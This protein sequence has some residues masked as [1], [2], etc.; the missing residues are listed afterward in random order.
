MKKE[1]IYDYSFIDVNGEEHSLS[2]FR[3]K[4]ILIVNTAIH[5]SFTSTY[6]DLQRT[7]LKY[8]QEGLEIIDFPCNQFHGQAS[9]SIEE[10]DKFCRE[11]YQ[12]TFL[13]SQKVDVV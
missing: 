4:I 1:N 9:E 3:G 8:H 5:C 10:I 7:Y 12:T 6:K 11:E 13:R 2:S